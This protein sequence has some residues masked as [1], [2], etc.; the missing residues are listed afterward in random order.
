MREVLRA[1]QPIVDV[2]L[3][4]VK[5]GQPRAH[6]VGWRGAAPEAG[7]FSGRS[8]QNRSARSANSLA[9]KGTLFLFDEPTTGLHFDDIAK[10]MRALR[11]L[12]EAGHSADRD[13]AQPGRDPRQRL[14]DRPGPE[15]GEAGGQLVAEGTPEE[16]RQVTRI[17]H[18]AGAARATTLAMGLGGHARRR[19]G[20]PSALRNAAGQAPRPKKQPMLR[21][22]MPSK[23][24]TPTST[25]S[26]T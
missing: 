6:A 13:R 10:L 5:L 20:G 12:L 3:D 23:S 15:G 1:L 16:L 25:T 11:K 17:A 14:A 19:S 26:R 9:R 24:S 7:G 18:R 22:A 4:Y 21:T 8:G 2:G